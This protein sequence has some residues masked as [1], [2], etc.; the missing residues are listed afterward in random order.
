M[1]KQIKCSRNVT[2]VLLI[3]AQ[4]SV[5]GNQSFAS[6]LILY[7]SKTLPTTA[8]PVVYDVQGVPDLCARP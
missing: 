5:N 4:R 7:F 6:E 8:V 2:T 3:G 1:Y